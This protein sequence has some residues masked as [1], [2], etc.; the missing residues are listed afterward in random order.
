MGSVQTPLK[1]ASLPS[2]TD[3]TVQV[4]KKIHYLLNELCEMGLDPEDWKEI[5][6]S[7][8]K[9]LTELHDPHSVLAVLYR[10]VELRSDSVT[11]GK[12]VG[13][14]LKHFDDLF[15]RLPGEPGY[16]IPS[17]TGRWL[18]E[19]L[20]KNL[21]RGEVPRDAGGHIAVTRQLALTVFFSNKGVRA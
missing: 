13:K 18:F 7:L 5:Y 10:A 9:Q 20:V 17:S 14:F 1:N 21:D 15:E 12:V 4:S 2:H 11:A 16:F 3:A 8:V 6:I 19:G